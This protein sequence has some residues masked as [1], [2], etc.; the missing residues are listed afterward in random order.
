MFYEYGTLLLSYNEDNLSIVFADPELVI[1]CKCLY[2]GLA[3][4]TVATVSC[5][6][7]RSSALL[8]I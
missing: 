3:T 8:A 1:C 6:F 2:T 7:K 5:F 4:N